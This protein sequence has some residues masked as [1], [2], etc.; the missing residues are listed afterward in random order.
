MEKR[1]KQRINVCSM[2]SNNCGIG[3]FQKM[4]KKEETE[5]FLIGGN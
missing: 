5:P 3:A 4:K 1:R 2:T